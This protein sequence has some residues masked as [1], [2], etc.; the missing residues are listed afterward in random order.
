V[1]LY[2]YAHVHK[3]KNI[4]IYIVLTEYAMYESQQEVNILSTCT[5]S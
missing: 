4:Y 1:Y 5:K 3:K 2:I